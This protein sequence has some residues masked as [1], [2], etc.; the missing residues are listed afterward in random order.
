MLG[1]GG[2]R[3]LLL[4]TS[5]FAVL[6]FF[7]GFV[8]FDSGSLVLFNCLPLDVAPVS[9]DERET[10]GSIS[11]GF[12][13]GSSIDDDGSEKSIRWF[14][15]LLLRLFLLRTLLLE[16]P[17]ELLFSCAVCCGKE[18]P[19]LTREREEAVFSNGDDNAF[20]IRKDMH[21]RM[22]SFGRKYNSLFIAADWYVLSFCPDILWGVS[23]RWR[24]NAVTMAKNSS[25]RKPQ[26][27]VKLDNRHP[28]NEIDNRDTY[29]RMCQCWEIH[30][31]PQKQ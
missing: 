20:S 17:E 15:L 24:I 16:K 29:V 7:D 8:S 12:L 13:L 25:I 23:R 11:S 5:L 2:C 28:Y 6:I 10:T 19:P 9:G 18:V 21:V 14:D 30:E 1:L 31:I 22:I 4:R 26:I 27:G 3:F